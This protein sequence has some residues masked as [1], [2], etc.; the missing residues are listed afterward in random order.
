[1]GGGCLLFQ[2]YSDMEGAKIYMWEGFKLILAGC[3]IFKFRTNDNGE[4]D[5]VKHNIKTIKCSV[6][7]IHNVHLNYHIRENEI[8][9]FIYIYCRP[10][11]NIIIINKYI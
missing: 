1:M 2:L 5:H 11:T 9:F 7:H 8:M 3:L 10:I 4:G 6:K